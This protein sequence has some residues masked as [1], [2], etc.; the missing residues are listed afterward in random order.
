MSKM[1][2]HTILPENKEQEKTLNTCLCKSLIES[3]I[4]TI[5]RDFSDEEDIKILI[6]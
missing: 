3:N 4:T 1:K 5:L 6:P 2:I